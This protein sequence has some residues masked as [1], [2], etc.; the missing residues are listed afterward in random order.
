MLEKAWSHS[1]YY[2][3]IAIKKSDRNTIFD[4][5]WHSIIVETEDGQRLEAALTESFWR[6]CSELRY[7]QV[8]DWLRENGLARRADGN[9]P[10]FDLRQIGNS[11]HFNLTVISR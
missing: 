7:G 3:G 6:N 1:G 2:R 5:F 9:P 10:C 8:G 11:N 4:R